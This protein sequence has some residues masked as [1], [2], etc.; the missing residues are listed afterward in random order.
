MGKLIALVRTSSW[1]LVVPSGMPQA[2][3]MKPKTPEMMPSA[4]LP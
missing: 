2:N 1:L 3:Q 4:L